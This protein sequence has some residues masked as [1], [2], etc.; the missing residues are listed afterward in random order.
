MITEE[1]D[2]GLVER[3]RGVIVT[4]TREFEGYEYAAALHAIEDAFW[5]YC[6]NYLELVKARSYLDE[7]T[8]ARRSALAA[9]S[10]STRLFLRLFAPF[11]PFVTEEVW[12]WTQGEQSIHISPWPALEELKAVPAPAVPDSFA[13]VTDVIAQVR[14]V[15]SDAKRAPAAVLSS[16]TVHGPS[17]MIEGLKLLTTDLASAS[18]AAPDRI[19]FTADA[20]KQLEVA[21]VIAE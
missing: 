14:K 10:T 18:R 2:R 1:L 13:A 17:P 16:L 20:C 19:S 5:N 21:A 8:P 12:S 3:L 4:A 6:D 15:K 11:M 7:D 9:L